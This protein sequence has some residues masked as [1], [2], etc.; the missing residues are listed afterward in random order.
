MN[1]T[2]LT[3]AHILLPITCLI[4]LCC[5]DKSTSHT[6]FRNLTKGLISAFA[7]AGYIATAG[8]W[9]FE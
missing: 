3:S 6:I 4:F 7:L 2:G 5:R 1:T 9:R 8:G